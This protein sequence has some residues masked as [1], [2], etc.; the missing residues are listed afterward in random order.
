[1]NIKYSNDNK[2][3]RIYWKVKCESDIPKITTGSGKQVLGFQQAQ[4]VC[5]RIEYVCHSGVKII[6]KPNNK[7]TV[8]D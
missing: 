7:S 2:R 8:L 1:M 4:R 6:I 5:I 3:P